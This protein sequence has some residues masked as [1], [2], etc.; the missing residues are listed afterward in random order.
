MAIL[1]R[2]SDI[3]A[4]QR[5][6][7]W[8]NV[9]CDTLGPL[10]FRSDPGTPLRGE[11]AAGQLG[12]V[13]VGRVKTSTPHSVYRT[14]GLIRR[15]SPEL[16]R[17]ALTMSGRAGLLQDG[18]TAQLRPGE[19]TLYDFTRPYE[20]AYDSGVQLA[21]FS[22]PREMLALP[23][24]LVAKL[25]AVPVRTDAGTGA[26]AAPLLRRVA[27]DMDSYPPGSAVRLSTVVMNLVTTAVAEHAGQAGSLSAESRE[28]TLLLRIHAFIEEHLGD[29]GLVPAAVAAAHYISVRYLYRLFEAQGTTVAAW[30]RHRRLERCRAD[31]ADPAFGSAPVSAVAGRWGLPDSAHFNRLFKRTYGLPPAEYRRACLAPVTRHPQGHLSGCAGNVNRLAAGGNATAVL[32]AQ[33]GSVRG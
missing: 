4:A 24:D 1:I 33:T 19:F 29:A 3:P 32:A 8:R 18:R 16:Y 17:V 31:L 20:L 7:A 25:T 9:V 28:Q 2:T 26:L 15:D 30:I 6:D 12:P 10:D 27:L 23:A 13:N 21:V 11:I 5:H 22:F 14:P